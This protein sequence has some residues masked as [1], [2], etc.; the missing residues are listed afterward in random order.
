MTNKATFTRNEVRRSSTKIGK[1][2]IF[3]LDQQLIRFDLREGKMSSEMKKT[4]KQKPSLR[5]RSGKLLPTTS[6]ASALESWAYGRV[7]LKAVTP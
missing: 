1:N 7:L 4:R 6:S 3:S 2:K 5:S